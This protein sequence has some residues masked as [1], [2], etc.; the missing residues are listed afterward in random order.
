[1]GKR[2]IETIRETDCYHSVREGGEEKEERRHKMGKCKEHRRRGEVTNGVKGLK[3]E[4]NFVSKNEA[5]P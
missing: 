4:G 5:K 3:R 1:M 2:G